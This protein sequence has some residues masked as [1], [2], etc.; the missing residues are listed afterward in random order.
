MPQTSTRIEVH[1]FGL[2]LNQG[3]GVVRG[4]GLIYEG[5]QIH[6]LGLDV[7]EFSINRRELGL[8]L[9]EPCP[10]RPQVVKLVQGRGRALGLG[11]GLGQGLHLVLDDRLR[12]GDPSPCLNCIA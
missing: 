5:S 8:A 2:G 7:R 11:Q 9:R 1:E 10:G 12:R 3:P 4:R 6:A